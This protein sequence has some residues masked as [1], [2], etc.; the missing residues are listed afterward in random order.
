MSLI[1]EALKRQQED[2]G[3]ENQE[4]EQPVAQPAEAAPQVKQQ[5]EIAP[6]E[7]PRTLPLK[8]TVAPEQPEEPAGQE[9]QTSDK[10]PDQEPSEPKTESASRAW[11]SLL[12][13]LLI[14][15]VIIGALSW[16][17]SI[18]FKKW[19][20]Q[21]EV[22]SDI[23][24]Q[25]TDGESEQPVAVAVDGD[26][27]Q[28]EPDP[29]VADAGTVKPD[30][31]PE[32]PAVKP[33]TTVAEAPAATT[34]P[35]KP[36]EIP[37]PFQL[38]EDKGTTEPDV[39]PQAEPAVAKP[40]AEPAAEPPVQTAKAEPAVPSATAEPESSQPP[41]PAAWPS[42]TLGGFVGA[43]NDGTAILNG[44]FIS[45]G[46]TIAGVKLVGLQRKSVMLSYNGKIQTLKIGQTTK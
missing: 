11:L 44:E 21:Q 12:S 34:Q 14:L 26:A 42:V 23:G 33:D 3:A 24:M 45:V 8:P 16:G 19:R 32:T 18:A 41:P 43:G 20:A 40:V 30:D 27:T 22:A 2:Q 46:E 31:A 39:K 37:K 13:V 17:A 9:P 4:E 6:P 36:V 5:G 15:F 1:Q 35:D 10:K 7:Q 38:V 29:P 28:V 25:G